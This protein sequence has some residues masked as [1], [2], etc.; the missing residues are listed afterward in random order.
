LNPGPVS[1]IPKVVDRQPVADNFNEQLT[2]GLVKRIKALE[3]AAVKPRK[4]EI[5]L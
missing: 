5:D 1:G 2:E 3:D 4:P